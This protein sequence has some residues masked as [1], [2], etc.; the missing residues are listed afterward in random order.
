MEYWV[1]VYYTLLISIASFLVASVWRERSSV[2]PIGTEVTVEPAEY[3]PPV[4]GTIEAVEGSFWARIE[5]M[6]D[7]TSGVVTAYV[8]G[9][10][11][12]YIVRHF[13]RE[14]DDCSLGHCVSKIK[15]S[16][17][18][19]R[20][21][22][23]IAFLQ[24]T[25]EKKQDLWSS[26][27][28]ATDRQRFFQEWHTNGRASAMEWSRSDMAERQRSEAETAANSA[29][30]ARAEAAATSAAAANGAENTDPM[31]QAAKDIADA[32]QRLLKTASLPRPRLAPKR[33]PIEAEYAEWLRRLDRE[34]FFAW[35]EDTDNATHFKSK[36]MLQY[37]STR[38]DETEFLK[39]VW[40]EFG[41]PGH[42][43]GPW[44]G[45][46]AMVKTKVSRDLT[47]GQVLT[48][49]GDINTALEVCHLC[50]PSVCAI[51]MGHILC[52]PSLCASG[53][54][55]SRYVLHSSMAS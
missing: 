53:T 10:D 27:A 8:E 9:E 31:V 5:S 50:V 44:D 22:H 7:A 29:D 3:E 48:P 46:G 15:R 6:T 54:A 13:S 14:M 41:C 1:I 47:N 2:L 34:K 17:L 51:C 30:T 19:Q 23:R 42:G 26:S 21:R 18:R 32:A 43:K 37:W 11:V 33:A 52:V 35:L 40:V 55:L 36:E 12:E 4:D 45:L 20:K 24:I 38:I 16:R 49:S 39:I 25:N 28:F